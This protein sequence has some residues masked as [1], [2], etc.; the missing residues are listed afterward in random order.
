MKGLQTLSFLND[1]KRKYL[2]LVPIVFL[3]L[4]AYFFQYANQR[5]EDT[6]LQ[7]KYIETVNHVNMLAAAVEANESR[8]WEDHE[9]NIVDAMSFVDML[10]LTFAAVYKPVDGE[11]TLISE[12]DYATTFDPRD[13]DKFLS[14]IASQDSG[15]V[16]VGFTPQGGVYRDMHLYY[17]HMPLYAPPE[18]RYLAVTGISKYSVISKIPLWVSAGQWV[19][20]AQTFALQVWI[21]VLVARVKHI[22][23]AQ[24]E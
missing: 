11:L 21:I 1:R 7:E 17:T 3:L 5:I 24:E 16:V 10:P 20:M 13:Y 18:Q 9:H 14:A 19:S 23:A 15:N 12:R 4:N 6:I 2:I 8:F 22:L